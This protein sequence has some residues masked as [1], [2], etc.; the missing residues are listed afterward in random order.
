MMKMEY[1]QARRV[2]FM[3][4]YTVQHTLQYISPLS[5][6]GKISQKLAATRVHSSSLLFGHDLAEKKGGH[7]VLFDSQEVMFSGNLKQK[8]TFQRREEFGDETQTGVS[9]SK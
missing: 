3:V 6:V 1:F 5:C 4:G 8:N 9:F 7:W 2:F